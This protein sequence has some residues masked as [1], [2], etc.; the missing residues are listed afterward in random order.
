[1]SEAW[2]DKEIQFIIDDYFTMLGKELKSE[3]FNKAEHGRALLPKLNNRSKGSIEFKHQNISAILLELKC[4]YISGYK[5]AVNYQAALKIAIQQRLPI[6]LFIHE[7]IELDLSREIIIPSVEDLLSILVAR[8][9][10]S[11]KKVAE[12]NTAYQSTIPSKVDYLRREAINQS[13]GLIGE[14]FALNYERARLTKL[15]QQNL[16]DKIEHTSVEQGDCTGFDIHS[17]EANGDDRFIEVKTTKYGKYTPF[18]VSR[19]ELQA[20]K[21]ISDQYHLYRLFDF[22]NL[23]GMYMIQGDLECQISLEAVQFIAKI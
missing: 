19:N 15:G 21:K 3:T 6:E 16:A 4:P 17:Y 14:K 1:M 11:N 7:L 2:S 20:S 22:R 12:P 10:R 9:E 18:Y 5:P 13:L 8:P 23:P